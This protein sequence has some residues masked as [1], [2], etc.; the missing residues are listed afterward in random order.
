MGRSLLPY[1]DIV[2]IEAKYHVL[3]I[4]DQH[5]VGLTPRIKKV[6]CADWYQY[7]RV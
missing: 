6:F 1:L 3:Y 4:P 5:D 7:R 2:V